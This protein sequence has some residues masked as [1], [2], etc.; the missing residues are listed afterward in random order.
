VTSDG[1]PDSV[2]TNETAP[3]RHDPNA[4]PSKN[5][6]LEAVRLA[7]GGTQL[8]TDHGLPI[9]HTEDSLKAGQRGPTLLEDFNF[10]EKLT[11]FDHEPIPERVVHARG[12][13]VHGYFEPYESLADVSRAHLFSDPSVRTPVFVRFSQVTWPRGTA[14]TVRDVR[15]F[16]VKFYTQEGNWD[17]VGN[18]IPVFFIQDAIQFPDLVHAL[19]PEPHN[20]VPT[21]STAH[22]T[23][24]DFMS[25]VPESTHM[26]MWVLSD[27][28][29]PRSYRMMEGFGVNTYRLV[30]A[31]GVSHLV[32]FHWKPL[33]GTHSLVFDEAQKLGGK[34]PDF[35]RRDLYEAIDS[36]AP[37]EFELGVQLVPEGDDLKYGFDLLDCTKLLPEEEVP[38]RPV[39]RMVLDQLP[40]NF[41]AET[42]QVA[43]L[44]TNIVPGIDFTDDPILQGRLYSYLDTQLSRLGGPNFAQIPINRPIA[45]VSNNNRAGH[46]HRETIDKG[47]ASYYPNSIGG[48]CPVLADAST[49]YVPRVARIDGTTVRTRSE[50]FKDHFSQATLFWNSLTPTEQDHVVTAAHYELGK[51]TPAH[52]RERMVANFNQVD[53]GLAVRVAQGV[54]VA[55]PAAPVVENHG[56]SS[57]A[58][59]LAARPGAGIATRKVAVIAFPGF[60]NDD[61]QKICAPLQA[62][63]AL[64]EVISTARGPMPSSTGATYEV[65]KT[66]LTTGSVMYDAVYLLGNANGVDV[67]GCP[68]DVLQFVQESFRHAK[69]IAAIGTGVE[70][71]RRANLPV[72]LVEGTGLV[73]DQGVITATAG[74]QEALLEAFIPALTTMRHWERSVDAVPA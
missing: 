59:S 15:G 8:T 20:E 60:D 65:I 30:N 54:G 58:L 12:T 39:G 9:T 22:D 67:I 11:H 10:R 42:E 28:A 2:S 34:D 72:R 1:S 47:R 40:D 13:G 21:G 53:H 61:L 31:E 70:I 74:E 52:I 66:F 49:G 18:N 25:L 56:K 44:P 71:V 69:T 19:K 45:P 14:D 33:L 16:A 38:V 73:S 37:V 68:G 32:K 3:F 43:F 63:G 50:S 36:G 23:A 24:W 17:L 5:E 7:G 27:R 35:L 41:F 57:P 51:V 64:P 6:Q 48:G 26:A 46:P 29:I 55:P 4:A 62:Q